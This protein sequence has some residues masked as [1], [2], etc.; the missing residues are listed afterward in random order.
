MDNA[1]IIDGALVVILIGGMLVGAHRGLFKSLMGMVVV[2]AALIGAVWL[3][4]LLADPIAD[5]IAPRVEDAVV[6]QFSE[7]LDKPA[8][9]D[10]SDAEGRRGLSELLEAYDLPSDLLDSLLEPLSGALSTAAAGAKEKA[11]ELFRSAVSASVKTLVRGTVHTV[12]VL[13]LYVILLVALKLLT[14]LLDHV[15]DL[16][17]LSAVNGLGGAAFGLLETALLLYVAIYLGAHFGV[18]LITEHAEDTYLL[19]IFINHSPVELLSR[20]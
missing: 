3:A 18:K 9:A 12:L 16:P 8:E 15:F 5:M 14:R 7:E 6:K 11:A 4:D 10:A 20:L 1:L 2:L 19:P 13:V 17:V